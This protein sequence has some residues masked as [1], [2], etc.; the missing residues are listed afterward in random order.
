MNNYNY[1][2]STNSTRKKS[3]M[4]QDYFMKHRLLAIILFVAVLVI[5]GVILYILFI[6]IIPKQ[7]RQEPED[8]PYLTFENIDLVENPFIGDNLTFY[9]SLILLSSDE[10][11]SAPIDTNNRELIVSIIKNS[12]D[13]NLGSTGSVSTVNIDISDGRKYIFKTLFSIG[14]DEE[15]AVAILDRIDSIDAKDYIITFTNYTNNYYTNIGTNDPI[16][17]SPITDYITGAPL[18]PL[19]KSAMDWVDS[20]NLNTPQTFNTTILGIR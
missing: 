19:P 5:I 6:K 9:L 14:Y 13:I 10:L 3:F 20:L 7:P 18:R 17:P 4:M 8:A 12:D 2:D 15:H 1:P 11:N 16:E